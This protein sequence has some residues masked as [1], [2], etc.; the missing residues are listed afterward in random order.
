MGEQSYIGIF[1]P[2]DS[3]QALSGI[4][5]YNND[6]TV[7]FPNFFLAGGATEDPIRVADA[8]LMLE[9][10]YG[11][12]SDW[13]IVDLPEPVCSASDGLYVVFHLPEGSECEYEG[14]GG[15]AGIGYTSGENGLVGWLS[16]DGEE[17]MRLHPSFGMAVQPILVEA[18]P[19][20]M[21]MTRVQPGNEN[22]EEL[23]LLPQIT[24][25]LLP[26]PNPSNP[27]TQ[28]KFT[29]RRDGPVKLKVYNIRGQ[30]IK[31]L[32]DEMYIAGTHSVVWYG[33]DGYGRKVS[34]GTYV[35]RF[36][37]DGKTMTHRVV[38]VR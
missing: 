27:M 9:D 18:E 30:L 5:W 22:S 6:A 38:I 26:R 12:S 1:V 4:K 37:A 25:L 8:T 7:V 15:G 29:L 36:Q 3:G 17:W 32:I 35:G 31:T 11:I 33:D 34:S 20:M 28:F 2:L 13:S 14:L 24:E 10:V 23:N 19:G 21:T 16:D